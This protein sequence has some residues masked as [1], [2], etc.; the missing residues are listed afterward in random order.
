MSGRVLREPLSTGSIPGPIAF[1]WLID[2]ACLLWQDQCGQRGSCF[3]YHNAAMSQYMLIAGLVYKVSGASIC[4]R[5]TG[6][7]ESE[8]LL[9][10]AKSLLQLARG[11]GHSTGTFQQLKPHWG[12]VAVGVTPTAWFPETH[13]FHV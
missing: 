9:Q 6:G 7:R 3:L 5:G 2:K 10:K 12:L 4:S 8:G 1:G 13:P 11:S